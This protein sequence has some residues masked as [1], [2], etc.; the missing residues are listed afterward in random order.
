MSVS[1]H[2]IIR[3]NFLSSTSFSL[4]VCDPS[5]PSSSR[6]HE[7]NTRHTEDDVLILI[8][9]IERRRDSNTSNNNNKGEKQSYQQR[10]KQHQNGVRTRMV[11][12]LPHSLDCR[13]RGVCYK[14]K[15]NNKMTRDSL[16]RACGNL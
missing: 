8:E 16:N 10:Q 3:E 6:S 7:E 15:H 14:C 4:S 2:G 1:S 12:I 5:T 11:E 9:Q 13:S